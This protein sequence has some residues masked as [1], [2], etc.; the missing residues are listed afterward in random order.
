MLSFAVQKLLSFFR[1]HLFISVFIFITLG[2]GS[3]RI[4]LW[5]ISYSVLP[6]FSFKSF[7]VSGL[8]CRSLIHFEF[9]F[10]YGV[11]KCSNFIPLPVAVQ[12]LQHD[13]L[14]RLSFHHC[15]FLTSLSKIRWPYVHLFISG[16]SVLF[17]WSAFLF[18]CQC[19]TVL[20]TVALYYSLKSRSLIPPAPDEPICG[21]GI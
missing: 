4:L 9:I 21:A 2:G 12:F 8:T 18:W 15:I 1:S 17:H 14:K 19:H 7:I 20:M 11:R 3:K 16:L 5:F 10:M 13:L 6:M